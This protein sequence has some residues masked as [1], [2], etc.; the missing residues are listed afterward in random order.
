M[1]YPRSRTI[2]D[3]CG[4]RRGI[5]I[6]ELLA[7]SRCCK[8]KYVAYYCDEACQRE[9]FANHHRV[10]CT[11]VHGGDDDGA[12]GYEVRD[13]PGK[14]SGIFATRRFK[15]GQVIMIETPVLRV[16]DVLD[17]RIDVAQ[18]R[19]QYD[20]CDSVT[21]RQIL[22][23]TLSNNSEARLLDAN[24][25]YKRV[26]RIL[27]NNAY[28]DKFNMISLLFIKMS[29]F[30]HSCTPNACF[31][32]RMDDTYRAVCV[33]DIS[34]GNEITVWYTDPRQTR[35][36]RQRILLEGYGFVCKCECCSL[37]GDAMRESDARRVL[38]KQ[39]AQSYDQAVSMIDACRKEK[40]HH[41]LP[42]LMK[43]AEGMAYF[44]R[45]PFLV[46]YRY[47][48]NTWHKY[49][50]LYGH[51]SAEADETKIYIYSDEYWNQR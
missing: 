50:L 23:L 42:P 7:C 28:P 1:P 2:C 30:N 24:D 15:R 45:R 19:H 16:R 14:G 10:L 26:Q 37:H 34:P 35:E 29:R 31:V 4:K 3:N 9:A 44:E 8:D 11:G 32:T 33:R 18:L 21:K 39:Q 49:E 22:N 27:I 51:D 5:D 41:L 40:L 13:I 20:A 38:L 46:R 47:T 25:E 48:A 12:P 36:N 6:G 43:L 17:K